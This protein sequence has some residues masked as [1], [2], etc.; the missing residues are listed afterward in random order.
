MKVYRFQDIY[1]YVIYVTSG[2]SL[3]IE[4]TDS[5][6]YIAKPC[7]GEVSTLWCITIYWVFQRRTAHGLYGATCQFNIQHVAREKPV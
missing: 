2:P 6:V 1:V 3:L 7:Y 5:M 4:S